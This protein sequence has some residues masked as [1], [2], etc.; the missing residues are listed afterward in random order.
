MLGC[1]ESSRA[2]CEA[3]AGES[4]LSRLE[5]AAAGL[6]AKKGH[7]TQ[8][9]FNVLDQLLVFCEDFPVMIRLRTAT[10]EAAAGV[11]ELIESLPGKFDP[12]E[13]M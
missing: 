1:V 13:Q 5:V 10:K 7:K 6:H 2:D 4:M 12:T 8:V 3:L 9:D 11:A